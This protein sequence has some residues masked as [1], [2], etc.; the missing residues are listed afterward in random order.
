MGIMAVLV[1]VSVSLQKV[2]EV[3]LQKVAEVLLKITTRVH[4]G[5]ALVAVIILGVGQR[6]NAVDLRMM[7]ELAWA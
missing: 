5:K 2:A 7:P 1:V 3:Y 6:E 4:C